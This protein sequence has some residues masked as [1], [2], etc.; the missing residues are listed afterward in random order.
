MTRQRL[1]PSL[2][3]ALPGHRN[4]GF[5]LIEIIITI[6][7]IGILAVVGSSMISDSFT[8]TRMVNASHAS[9]SE[10]RYALERLAREIREVKFVSSGD[11]DNYCIT[12]MTTATLVLR[13][14]IPGSL[15]GCSTADNTVTITWSNSN[16]T[17]TLGYSSPATT[18][19]TLS[20]QV[21][22]FSLTYFQNDGTEATNNSNIRFVVINMTVRD[23][24]SGRSIQQRTRVALRNA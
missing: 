22:S 20:D 14:S 16:D 12:T 9:A 19:L 21:T 18:L 2:S 8:T 4:S 10:A 13:K 15:P 5:T 1:S 3:A 17:L 6:V 11:T 23:L 24:T 7:L